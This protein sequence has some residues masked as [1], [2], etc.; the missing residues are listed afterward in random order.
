MEIK[1]NSMY[2][3]E[4]GTV[5]KVKSLGTYSVEYK[6]INKNNFNTYVVTSCISDKKFFESY[7][8][9]E[10][11]LPKAGDKIYLT[12][13]RINDYSPHVYKTWTVVS[14]PSTWATIQHDSGEKLNIDLL[15]WE[16]EVVNNTPV[17]YVDVIEKDGKFYTLTEIEQPK[18]KIG[19]IIDE[20]FVV[21]DMKPSTQ[22]WKYHMWDREQS[23]IKIV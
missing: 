14:I 22:G 18:H 13:N 10:F 1:V 5:V 23:K 8:S 12:R 15:N 2:R 16:W 11:I 17:E 20:N 7:Y 4:D 3:S 6:G 19:D 21:V 9:E